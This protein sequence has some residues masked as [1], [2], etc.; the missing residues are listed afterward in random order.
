[1]E[2]A[3][4]ADGKRVGSFTSPHLIDVT[5]RVRV[6]G[7]DVTPEQLD[8]AAQRVAAIFG[9]WR[10]DLCPSFFEALLLLALDEFVQQRIDTAIV[11]VAIGGYHDVVSLLSAP[12]AIIT[13]VG[14]DHALEL[15]ST[16]AEIARDKAGIASPNTSLVL[17]PRLPR[18]AIEAILQD[19]APRGVR[20]VEASLAALEARE[21]GGAGF[22]VSLST[23]RGNVDIKLPLPGRFQLDN[24]ATAA[25][26]F[27][28]LCDMGLANSPAS[29][30]G[31]ARV[32][33]PGRLEFIGG[34]PEWILDSA[35]NPL[36][37]S[38]LAEFLRG[39]PVARN[40]VLLFGT[41]ELNKLV[42][43]LRVL[44]P[45]FTRVYTVGGF[46]KAVSA[47]GA[48]DGSCE[49]PQRLQHFPT[50]EQAIAQVLSIEPAVESVVV[51]G[52]V[53]LVGAC[54]RVLLERGSP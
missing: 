15:G 18:A 11:E 47:P 20:L 3:L 25:T 34:R 36:A 42:E 9:A 14:L 43:G 44:A 27:G 23:A 30:T 45:L 32:R 31:V 38:A 19:A 22:E 53:Y 33:W 37:F 46:Y 10:P 7:L 35:H 26:A 51:A 8:R 29:L 2:A 6:Q 12:V 50:P 48:P 39:L 54:R 17:G 28:I 49:E 52:S 16:I 1:L 5:E 41:S 4:I 21:L 13:S 24:L 40:R